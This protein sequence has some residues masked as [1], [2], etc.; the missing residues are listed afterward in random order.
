M[1]LSVSQRTTAR[2]VTAMYDDIDRLHDNDTIRSIENR[3]YDADDDICGD[4]DD[5]EDYYDTTEEA[6]D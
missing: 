6:Y 2:T 5:D 4:Y 1:P 3:Y